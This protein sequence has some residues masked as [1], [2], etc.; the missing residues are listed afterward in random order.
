[1][2][3]STKF[4]LFCGSV[5]KLLYNSLVN[6]LLVGVICSGIFTEKREPEKIVDRK[7]V[8]SEK[9]ASHI[10]WVQV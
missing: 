2:N 1:M 5:T 9:A 4:G 7:G 8:C 3:L 6:N 10:R